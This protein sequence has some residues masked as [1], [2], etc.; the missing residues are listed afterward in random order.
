MCFLKR[1]CAFGMEGWSIRQ[2]LVYVLIVLMP[3]GTSRVSVS[4]EWVLVSILGARLQ[5]EWVHPWRD[6]PFS[7]TWRP[8][9]EYFI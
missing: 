8:V 5:T 7:V 3:V 9:R 2:S 6:T 1:M 4:W